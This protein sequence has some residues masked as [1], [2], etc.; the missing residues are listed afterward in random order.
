MLNVFHDGPVQCL[1]SRTSW[2]T[3][4]ATCDRF[5][6]SARGSAIRSPRI[7]TRPSRHDGV[8]RLSGLEF[9]VTV[10]VGLLA[11]GR[12][13]IAPPRIEVAADVLHQRGDA[14]GL[15]IQ[16]PEELAVVHLRRGALGEGSQGAVF[17]RQRGDEVG[18]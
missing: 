15:A 5:L 2:W 4:P 14:V 18:G 7:T 11:I 6:A 1:A 17:V 9:R 10:T 3:C 13:E 16:R 8:A 12:P